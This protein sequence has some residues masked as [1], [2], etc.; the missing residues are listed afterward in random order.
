MGVMAAEALRKLNKVLTPSLRRCIFV[1]LA[2]VAHSVRLQLCQDTSQSTGKF[3]LK[4]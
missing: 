2:C 4:D 3:T 1:R